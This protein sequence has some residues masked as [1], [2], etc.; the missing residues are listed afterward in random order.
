[1]GGVR[2]ASN[3]R[4]ERTN[5]L[6]KNHYRLNHYLSNNNHKKRRIPF[7]F[8]LFHLHLMNLNY[9]KLKTRRGS[10]SAFDLNRY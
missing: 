5:Q 2:N 3:D 9:W 4:G 6:E 10:M 8:R 7:F 1:M